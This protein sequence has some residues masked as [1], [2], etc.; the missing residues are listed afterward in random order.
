MYISVTFGIRGGQPAIHNELMIVCWNMITAK[1]K[2]RL[3][4]GTLKIKSSNMGFRSDITINRSSIITLIIVVRGDRFGRDPQNWGPVSQ[5]VPWWNYLK[6]LKSWKNRKKIRTPPLVKMILI[7]T[8]YLMT[9]SVSEISIMTIKAGG[10]VS[11]HGPEFAYD[12]PRNSALKR[13]FG[14]PVT[15]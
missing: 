11:S 3:R 8:T 2:K 14:N 13:R 6:S 1:K 7:S 15:N 4:L 9:I 5:Q 12:M 10:V